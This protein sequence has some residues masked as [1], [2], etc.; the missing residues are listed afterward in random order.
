L[1]DSH[2]AKEG[3]VEFTLPDTTTGV[4]LQLRDGGEVAEIPIDLIQTL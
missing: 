2:S 3:T 4:I 1:V